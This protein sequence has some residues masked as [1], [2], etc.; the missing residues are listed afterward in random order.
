MQEM[1]HFFG[2]AKLPQDPENM[3]GFFEYSGED[4]ELTRQY[5]GWRNQN[6]DMVGWTCQLT[7]PDLEMIQYKLQDKSKDTEL[8]SFETSGKA[9]KVILHYYEKQIYD[10]VSEHLD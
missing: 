2:Y 4:N 8:L 10:T 9:T 3:T 5:R 1:L 6:S 7:D